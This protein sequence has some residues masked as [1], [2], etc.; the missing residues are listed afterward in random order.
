MHENL[1]TE[2][3]NPDS[4][5]LELLESVDELDAEAGPGLGE[6]AR[7]L[8][9]EPAVRPRDDRGPPREVG[10][11]VAGIQLSG[12]PTRLQSDVF[13]DPP[14]GDAEVLSYLLTGRPLGETTTADDGEVPVG[15]VIVHEG[16]LIASAHNQ[17]EELSDP[18]AHAEMLVLRDAAAGAWDWRL[19]GHTLVVT[20]EPCA[21]CCGALI[22][23]RVGELVFAAAEPRA[24][25]VMSTRALLDEDNFN[26]RVAWR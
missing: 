12:T 9:S 1:T 8:E 14:M 11:V 6:R 16:R 10:D 21:M 20:L 7:R 15:C 4:A 18:T 24:G 2:A 23:A 25:A 19:A 26:H 5:D 17:R 13:S 3:V 22:H